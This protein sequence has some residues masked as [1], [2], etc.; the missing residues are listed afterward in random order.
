MIEDHLEKTERKLTDET[1]ATN[2]VVRNRRFPKELNDQKS[3]LIFDQLS[4]VI[5]CREVNVFKQIRKSQRDLAKQD[6][7]QS[8]IVNV[9]IKQAI[10]KKLYGKD[11]LLSIILYELF[12]NQNISCK[13]VYG[14]I[15]IDLENG[16]KYCL[17]HWWINT[18]TKEYDVASIVDQQVS[19]ELKLLLKNSKI[20]CS[21]KR[22]DYPLI[23]M[24]SDKN[25]LVYLIDK[26]L[27]D[28]YDKCSDFFWDECVSHSI[29][30]FKNDILNCLN[31]QTDPN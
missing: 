4:T 7:S 24:D 22:K 12:K 27:I 13:L 1:S 10:E 26:L 28:I 8:K 23:N 30:S 17:N 2:L 20:T 6:L 18:N 5:E 16:V 11:V 9:V 3:S 15:L 29:L 21:I 14:Y 19:P 31:D 25:M